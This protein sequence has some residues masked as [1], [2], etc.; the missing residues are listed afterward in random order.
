MKNFTFCNPTKI[1]FG[2]GS[3][4]KLNELLPSDAKVLLTY[5]GGSVITNGIYN[6]VLD[7]LMPRE[8]V[9]FGGIEPNPDCTTIDKAIEVG[10]SEGVTWVLALGGGSVLDASKVIAAGIRTPGWSSW[11]MVCKGYFEDALP[12]GT[13]LTVPATGSE[14][15]S[16][17]VISNRA[18]KEKFAIYTRHPQFSILD[19]TFTYTLSSHQVSCGIADTFMHTL[20]QY[21][22]TPGQSG[23]M[24]RMAEG[25]LLNVLDF[26]PLRLEKGDDYDVSCEYM[27][28]ATIALN[29]F[30]GMGVTQDWMTHR[31][32]HEVTA[33]TGTTHGAS[34]MMILPAMLRV[35]REYK[36][37]KVVQLGE[38]VFGIRGESKDEVYDATV[39]RIIQFIHS[40]GL[41]ASLKEAGI[42]AT[43]AEEIASRFEERGYAL[44]ENGIAPP[45]LIRAIVEEACK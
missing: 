5:G 35:M 14:M 18:L 24:D 29:G 36:M 21:L 27:L 17:S 41:H 39:E 2:R 38:R 42:P 43:V 16:G 23:V 45:E 25:I 31:I 4:E 9:P 32:G 44:G 10:R 11:D 15:N 28:S 30:L 7:Q 37:G 20:E 33:L 8:V 34:L 1:V 19:P 26:A 3:L 12:L 40:L 22:T 6:Q 13:I